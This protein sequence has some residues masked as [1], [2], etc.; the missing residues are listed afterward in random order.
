MGREGGGG[1]NDVSLGNV[2]M[3]ND[4][5]ILIGVVSK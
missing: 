2:R 1:V 3:V 5:E 4:A